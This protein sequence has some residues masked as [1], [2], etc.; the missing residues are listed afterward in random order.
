MQTERY[1]VR[2]RLVQ[3]KK[4]EKFFTHRVSS[5]LLPFLFLAETMQ[6]VVLIQ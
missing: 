1:M 5:Y 4:D 6:Q 2:N 3:R